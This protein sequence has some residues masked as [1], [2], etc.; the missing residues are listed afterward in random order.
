MPKPS[1]KPKTVKRKMAKV[2]AFMSR[3][4]PKPLNIPMSGI[5]KPQ[6]PD[7]LSIARHPST[8]KLEV[9]R[10]ANYQLAMTLCARNAAEVVRH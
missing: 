6:R 9:A 2:P 3:A 1:N 5:N 7:Q 8:Q 4:E 10:R